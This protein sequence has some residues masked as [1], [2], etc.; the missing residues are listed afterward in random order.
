MN[1]RYLFC[2]TWLLLPIPLVIAQTNPASGRQFQADRGNGTYQNP[3][4]PGRRP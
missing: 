4:I 2:L 3:I 1:R